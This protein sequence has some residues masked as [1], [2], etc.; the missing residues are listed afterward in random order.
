MIFARILR[1]L[2]V[3]AKYDLGRFL[4]TYKKRYFSWYLPF[5]LLSAPV[6]LSGRLFRQALPP[7]RALRQALEEL[8]PIFIKFGQILSTRADL[9]DPRLIEELSELQDKV[10]PCPR[11]RSTT[12]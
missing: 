7:E 3:A 9:L 8:G 6:Q 5:M 11:T 12:R 2:F 1:I 4:T 10:A